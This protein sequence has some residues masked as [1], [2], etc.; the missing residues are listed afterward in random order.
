LNFLAGIASTGR[1]H[2]GEGAF[3]NERPL[4][5]RNLLV[6]EIHVSYRAG[7]PGNPLTSSVII[8]QRLGYVR[9]A[10]IGRL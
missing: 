1:H 8:S 6:S 5:Q 9:V 7:S 2:R 10:L 3:N 4:L